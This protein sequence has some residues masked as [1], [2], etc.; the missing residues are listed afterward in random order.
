MAIHDQ[1]QVQNHTFGQRIQVQ[2]SIDTLSLAFQGTV[3]NTSAV[4]RVRVRVVS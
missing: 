1:P 4:D 2:V 3:Y